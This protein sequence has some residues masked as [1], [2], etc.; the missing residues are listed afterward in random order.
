MHPCVRIYDLNFVTTPVC[1]G[2]DG[3][4]EDVRVQPKDVYQHGFSAALVYRLH[5]CHLLFSYVEGL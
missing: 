1:E 4:S 5:I 3:L 2:W